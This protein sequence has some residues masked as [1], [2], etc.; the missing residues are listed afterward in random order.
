MDRGL[1]QEVTGADQEAD[2]AAGDTAS[3][4]NAFFPRAVL[5][6]AR[7]NTGDAKAVSGFLTQVQ[8]AIAKE[9]TGSINLKLIREEDG[10]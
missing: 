2:R 9:G 10:E 7:V 4:A 5:C 8:E 1:E 6:K 3:G